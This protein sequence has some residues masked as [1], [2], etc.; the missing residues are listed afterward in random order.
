MSSSKCFDACFVDDVLTL[1]TENS[2]FPYQV[3]NFRKCEICLLSFQKETQFQRHMRDHEQ[4]DKVWTLVDTNL[5]NSV[6]WYSCILTSKANTR[7][8]FQLFLI[9]ITNNYYLGTSEFYILGSCFFM[10]PLRQDLPLIPFS[11]TVVSCSV[12]F[13]SFLWF[14]KYSGRWENV[15]RELVTQVS[16]L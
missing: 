10:F 9:T 8:Y 6:Y 5:E 4:N 13:N 2:N 7:H 11:H 16:V 3:S 15:Y 14:I 12:I 1:N